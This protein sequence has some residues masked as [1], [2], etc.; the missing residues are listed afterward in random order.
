MATLETIGEYTN[1][2]TFT[3]LRHCDEAIH[4][5]FHIEIK[6]DILDLRQIDCRP[7]LTYIFDYYKPWDID[8]DN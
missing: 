6:L 5:G 3:P 7:M 1:S 4:L 2:R 8:N